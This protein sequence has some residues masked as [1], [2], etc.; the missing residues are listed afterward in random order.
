M[1]ICCEGKTAEKYGNDWSER[2]TEKFTQY[3]PAAVLETYDDIAIFMNDAFDTDDFVYIAKAL[4]IVRRA[5]SMIRI[6][7]SKS[8]FP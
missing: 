1:N 4:D 3:D 7:E 8:L 6:E 5:Q 2:M